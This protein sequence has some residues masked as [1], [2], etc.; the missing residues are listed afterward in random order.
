MTFD[1]VIVSG[2]FDAL[3]PEPTL[4]P[5]WN[6]QATATSA[7]QAMNQAVIASSG[8]FG[9]CAPSNCITNPFLAFNK[10]TLTTVTS[11]SIPIQTG[12]ISIDSTPS[13]RSNN[14]W[15]HF[16]VLHEPSTLA[17]LGVGLFGLAYRRRVTWLTRS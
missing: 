11:L 1:V 10:P 13:D 17:L 9:Y 14:I 6:D 16:T 5:F 4:I 2:A 8:A 7:A 15:A 12:V 3:Y